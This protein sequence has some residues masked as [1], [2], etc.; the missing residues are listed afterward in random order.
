MGPLIEGHL[1]HL[2]DR[3]GDQEEERPGEA[4]VRPVDLGQPVAP[5]EVRPDRHRDAQREPPVE[6]GDVCRGKRRVPDRGLMPAAV[7]VG[8][9][10]RHDVEGEAG[11]RDEAPEHGDPANLLVGRHLYGENPPARP[12]EPAPPETGA[13]PR[14]DQLCPNQAPEVLGELGARRVDARRPSVSRDVPPVR[15][16]HH[17]DCEGAPD[18]SLPATHPVDR[19]IARLRSGALVKCGSCCHRTLLSAVA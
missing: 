12:N 14:D 10:A 18:A 2:G 16:G 3:C 19:A 1:H 9:E 8:P 7:L 4:L 5:V 11:H 15:R 6:H 13:G 17:Y